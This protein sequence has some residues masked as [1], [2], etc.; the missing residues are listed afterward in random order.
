MCTCRLF[1]CI[2]FA[3]IIYS[4][5]GPKRIYTNAHAYIYAFENRSREI[6]EYDERI[7]LYKILTE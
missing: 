1:P 5:T 2:F 4:E 7:V 3:I 6:D